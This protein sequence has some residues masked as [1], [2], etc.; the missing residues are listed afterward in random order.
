[1]SLAPLKYKS[2]IWP[3]NPSTYTMRYEKNTAVHHYPY[4]NIN[5]VEDLGMKPREVSGTG[6][7]IGEGAYEEFGKLASV[8]YDPGPGLLVHPV[9]QIQQAV[10]TRLEPEQE[11]T[12]NYVRYS[13]SFIEHIPETKIVEVKKE[14]VLPYTYE[15]KPAMIS[16]AELKEHIVKKGECLSLIAKRYGTTW[17]EI[18]KKNPSIKNPNLIYPGQKLIV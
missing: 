1:M 5:E 11:P 12:P 10:F 4:T 18:V 17:K 9:W 2:Y 16:K 15:A 8:F 7:F 3:V 6:E 13:F 14:M